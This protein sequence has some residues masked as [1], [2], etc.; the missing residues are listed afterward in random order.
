MSGAA[1]ARATPPGAWHTFE[2]DG[3]SE[4][5]FLCC[6]APPYSHDDTIFE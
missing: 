2:N 6:C 4:L 1:F 5:R 3:N